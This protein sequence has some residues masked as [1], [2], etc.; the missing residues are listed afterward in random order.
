MSE[1]ITPERL[2]SW[3]KIEGL[4]QSA[5]GEMLGW[6]KL[7]V[8]KIE[9]GRRKISEPEQRLLKLLINGEPP[10]PSAQSPYD[11][12]IDFTSEEWTI[13]DHIAKREGY[14]GARQWIVQKIRDCLAMRQAYPEQQTPTPIAAASDQSTY[15]LRSQPN[16]DTPAAS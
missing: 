1:E 11:A 8:T 2:K 3:R 12:R 14:H 7:M 13:M 16:D 9:T 4:T 10:F 6:D 15:N 5:L